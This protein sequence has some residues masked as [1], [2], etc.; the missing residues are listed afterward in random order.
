MLLKLNKTIFGN[1][2][3]PIYAHYSK[4]FYPDLSFFHNPH[5]Q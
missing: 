4:N 2:I 1:N 3:Q 5:H